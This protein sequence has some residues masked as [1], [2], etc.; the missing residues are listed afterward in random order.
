MRTTDFD[1][2][3]A[4]GSANKTAAVVT[5]KGVHWEPAKQ[6]LKPTDAWQETPLPT[7]PLPTGMVGLIP[8]GLKVGRLTVIGYGGAG[9]DRARW[10]VRC[11]CGMYGHQRTRSLRAEHHRA[12]A[13]C[14][15]CNYLEEVKAGRHP[16]VPLR[17]DSPKPQS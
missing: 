2:I 7:F 16:V 9:R 11:A 6:L 12:R 4:S 5:G 10:V 8:V 14:L 17:A 1:R 15:R 3:V 13:M